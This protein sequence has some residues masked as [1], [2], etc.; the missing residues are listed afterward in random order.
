MS[1]VEVVELDGKENI[2]RREASPAVKLCLKEEPSS[3][4][5][6]E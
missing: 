4:C 6:E 1:R 2:V 3:V 5:G